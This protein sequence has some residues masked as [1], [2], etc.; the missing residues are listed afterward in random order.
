[1]PSHMDRPLATIH[2]LVKTQTQGKQYEI[3]PTE[4]I[5]SYF[6]LSVGLQ[7]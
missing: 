2:E 7:T 5:C 3:Q 6:L 1:M 4:L